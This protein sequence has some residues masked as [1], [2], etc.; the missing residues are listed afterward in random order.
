MTVDCCS[1][2]GLKPFD[3]AL[4]Q[5]LSS[6]NTVAETEQ[7]PLEQCLDRIIA[8]DLCAIDIQPPW[9]CSAMDGYGLNSQSF[10]AGNTLTMVGSSF[11]GHPY[12][13][14]VA[15]GQCI[16]IMTGAC[17]PDDCD[18]VVM[19]EN[20][21]ADGNN[22]KFPSSIEQ[23]QHVRKAGS[24]ME[25]GEIA[26]TKGQRINPRN[27]GVIASLGLNTVTV[28]RKLK[29]AV[30]STG[31]ELLTPGKIRQTGQIYDS[32]R[33][34]VIALCH[35][36]GCEVL[37]LGL[38]PDDRDLIKKVMQDAAQK[39]DVLLTSGG[40]SVG[41]ADYVKPIV[42][43]IGEINLWKVAIKPGKPIAIGSIGNCKF[44]GLPGNPVSA[45]VTMNLLVQ[46]AMRKMSGMENT[47]PTIIPA[48]CES[49]LSKRQGRKDYQR[50]NACTD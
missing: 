20:V 2:P 18:T 44:F 30:F 34:S 8:E 16:R 10:N 47:L 5:I 13:G 27:I 3:Q 26:L 50:G 43:E 21:E 23:W 33:Y 15:E 17:L 4:D 42:E 29:V 1:A 46:P 19:Q 12:D 38:I 24:D 45:T 7:L 25:V 35:R 31:D 9:N 28:F 49:N 37:D 11:A 48:I 14:E 36:L 40:V 39:V 41:E 6:V 32:N 22:I